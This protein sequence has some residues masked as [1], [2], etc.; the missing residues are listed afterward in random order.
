MVSSSNLHNTVLLQLI[1]KLQFLTS[2]SA[3][4]FASFFTEK[5]GSRYI[6]WSSCSFT[7]LL[8][9]YKSVHS[10]VH[11][12]CLPLC[13]YNRG[14]FFFSVLGCFSSLC[15]G[16]HHFSLIRNITRLL[17]IFAFWHSASLWIASVLLAFQLARVLSTRRTMEY[18]QSYSFSLSNYPLTHLKLLKVFL[19]S[20]QLSLCII[21]LIERMVCIL[22]SIFPCFHFMLTSQRTPMWL[23]VLST[24]LKQ[25]LHR[26]PMFSIYALKPA[27]IFISSFISTS[28]Q[29]LPCWL[30]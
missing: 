7:F 14:T 29:H 12:I 4:V 17:P 27:T 16:F 22:M 24:S 5:N 26:S 1:L 19:I 3:N 30:F 15:S 2:V 9:T 6:H 25:P 21:E 20:I 10:W 18:P 8:P 23:F 28:Y 13:Y 11:L